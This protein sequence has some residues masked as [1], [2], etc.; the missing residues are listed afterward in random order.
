MKRW[1]RARLFCFLTA[2]ACWGWLPLCPARAADQVVTDNGDSG[3]GTLRQ[4]ISDAG[5]GDTITFQLGAGSETVTIL[6]EL[7]I[8]EALT[9]DGANTAG[10]GIPV[11]VEVAAPGP[12]GTASRVFKVKVPGETVRLKNMKVRGGDVSALAGEAANGGG[13][14][15]AAGTLDLKRVIV[16]GSRAA[17]GGGVYND[18]GTLVMFESNVSGNSAANSGGGIYNNGSDSGSCSAEFTG[19]TVSENSAASHGGGI[20]NDGVDG[21]NCSAVLTGCTVS[22]NT[23]D[24]GSWGGWGGG[25]YNNG[26]SGT[27]TALFTNCTISGNSAPQVNGYGGGIY[28]EGYGNCSATLVGCTVTG[29]SAGAGAGGVYNNAASVTLQNSILGG[30]IA[31]FG[32]DYG[33][34]GGTATDD[35]YN[36]V[37]VSTIAWSGTG[38]I[39]GQD[40]LLGAL[41]DFGGKTKTHPLCAAGDSR[42]SGPCSGVSAGDSPALDRIGTGTGQCGASAP[43]NVDQRGVVRPQSVS[44]DM[45]AYERDG[46][47]CVELLSFSAR[48]FVTDVLLTWETASEVDSAGFHLWRGGEEQGDYVRITDGLI[49]ARG[50]PD[51][52]AA[53][54]FRDAGLEPGRTWYYK[55]EDVDLAGRSAFHGPVPAETVPA[56]C[57]TAAAS[58]GAN[59]LAWFLVALAAL[60]WWRKPVRGRSLHPDR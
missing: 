5:D 54:D 18:S 49:R 48:G 20:Y 58:T 1:N 25:I 10:S 45:G 39:N 56:F 60:R 43:Y 35:G 50:S 30:S 36:L 29:N 12:G 7:A 22:G 21:G 53:Y 44:C 6:S 57:G 23:A 3:A 34:N 37:Q 55:L 27:C 46:P 32:G 8:S 52:G 42:A 16:L 33:N 40:P 51:E 19:C 59:H 9:I 14:L 2:A 15:N 24:N 17:Y 11:R 31:P 38:T 26:N 41:G 47:L 28:C 13:I 4:A